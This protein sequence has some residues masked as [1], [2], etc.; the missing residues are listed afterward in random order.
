MQVD[1]TGG[2]GAMFTG[3]DKVARF[4]SIVR[5]LRGD[6]NC[7]ELSTSVPFILLQNTARIE[8]AYTASPTLSGTYNV[9]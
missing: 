9:P 6:Q 8:Y 4:C 7:T 2:G 3:C 1:R 5:V